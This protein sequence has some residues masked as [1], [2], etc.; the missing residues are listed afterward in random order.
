MGF[1]CG[2]LGFRLRRGVGFR[3]QR[4][5]WYFACSGPHFEGT[6]V[7]KVLI[8]GDWPCGWRW[9]AILSISAP[10][11]RA[12]AHPCAAA[13]TQASMPLLPGSTE[14]L[15]TYQDA[16]NTLSRTSPNYFCLPSAGEALKTN[17]HARFFQLR[18]STNNL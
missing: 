10:P 11:G 16:W 4:A 18:L 13:L 14:I 2:A 17:H 12:D 3:L 8:A 6:K 5:V 1:A 9:G 7:S 15:K